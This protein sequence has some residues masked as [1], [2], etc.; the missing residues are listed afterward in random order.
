VEADGALKYRGDA[1]AL[2]K[3]KRRQEALERAG[4][5]VVRV[6]WNDVLREPRQTAER[7]RAALGRTHG[8]R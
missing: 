6:T 5:V 8:T 7:V 1:N 3:E 4:W 2:W